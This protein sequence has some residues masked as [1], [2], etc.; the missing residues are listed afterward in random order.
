MNVKVL[1]LLRRAMS[2]HVVALIAQVR[3]KSREGHWLAQGQEAR[4]TA[5]TPDEHKVG[6]QF[7]PGPFFF[8]A[9]P[10][11]LEVC[12]WFFFPFESTLGQKP[13]L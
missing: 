2:R 4:G 7:T 10:W 9:V 13:D 3:N 8:F 11:L 12:F 1:W 5:L 6:T